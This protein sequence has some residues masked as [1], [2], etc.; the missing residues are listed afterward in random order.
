VSLRRCLTTRH[1]G[2][3]CAPQVI[4]VSTDSHFTH[5]AWA[6]TPRAEGDA[7]HGQPPP[8]PPTPCAQRLF[9]RGC[10]CQA[11]LRP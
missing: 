4:V 2:A 5:H 6:N 9:H 8:L 10:P 7:D 11:A 1:G 3:W